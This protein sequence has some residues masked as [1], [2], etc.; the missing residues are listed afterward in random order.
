VA[1]DGSEAER[2]DG[3]VAGSAWGS[4]IHLHF[5]ADRRLAPRFVASSSSLLH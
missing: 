3:S 2:T 4:Y 5:G 1:L